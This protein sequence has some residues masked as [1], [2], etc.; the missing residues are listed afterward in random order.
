MTRAGIKQVSQLEQTSKIVS[1]KLMFFYGICNPPANFEYISPSKVHRSS[2]TLCCESLFDGHFYHLSRAQARE[3]STIFSEV[4]LNS[5]GV[6][7][8][9]S[10]FRVCFGL[11]FSV[12]VIP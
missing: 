9:S 4:L 7:E 3:F 12:I 6:Y 8:R 10:N 1:Q 11:G 5:V 2:S